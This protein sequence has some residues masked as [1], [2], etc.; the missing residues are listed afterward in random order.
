MSN[1]RP[2]I[3]LDVA[4]KSNMLPDAE[5]C[6]LTW[7]GSY[8]YYLVDEAYADTRSSKSAMAAMAMKHA[9]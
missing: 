5:V 6:K 3:R 9:L 1:H 2:Q 8:S 4:L 7:S